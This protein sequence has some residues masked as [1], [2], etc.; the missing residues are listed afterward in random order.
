VPELTTLI[1]NR[2]PKLQ[3][4]QELVSFLAPASLEAEQYRTLRQAVE[5]LRRESGHQVIAITS[6][7]AGDG[8]TVTTLNLAGALAQSPAARVLVISA[9]LREERVT[10]YLGLSNGHAP[11]LAGAIEDT[12][13]RLRD[14]VTRLDAL[15]LSVLTA[16][17]LRAQPYELL[18]SF[19]FEALIA[20]ARELYDYVLVDTPPIVP[21]ADS[22][23]LGRWVDGFL[24]VVTA[25]LTPRKMVVEALNLLDPNKVVGLVFNGDDRPLTPYYSYYYGQPNKRPRR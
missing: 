8:K 10:E 23:L 14:A 12:N 25:H 3:L 6:A 19:R 7:G 18:A 11:G 13:C 9:D 5:R 16:G 21:L 15:N 2:Q 22:R 4:A 17:T 24:M 20:E 1:S